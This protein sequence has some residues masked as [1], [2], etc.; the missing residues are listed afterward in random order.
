MTKAVIFGEGYGEGIQKAG[1]SYRE[2]QGFRGFD[3]VVFNQ[4]DEPWWLNWNDVEETIW[5]VGAK[6]VP[7]LAD[8]LTTDDVIKMGRPVES[9]V[10]WSES[11]NRGFLREGLVART[12]PYLFNKHGKRVLFKLKVNDWEK[13]HG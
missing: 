9:R 7:V 4:I 13:V 1:G 12:N 3:V 6:T 2:G 11:N 5:S 8:S 10:S